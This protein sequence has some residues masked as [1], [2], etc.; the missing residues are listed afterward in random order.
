MNALN[1]LA[2]FL[3][4]ALILYLSILFH[5]LGHVVLG[6]VGGYEATSFGLGL[7][8]VIC[9]IPLGR[10]RLFFGLYRPLQGVTF[11][12]YP[13]F[14]PTRLQICLFSAGGIL[15]NGLLAL[16][17]LA[18]MRWLS[19]GKEAWGLLAS[20]NGLLALGS[21]VP[22][23]FQVGR[24]PLRSDGLLIL[25]TLLARTLSQPP[26]KTI[27]MAESL[28]GLFQATGDLTIHRVYLLSAAGARAE[29]A[30]VSRA[31]EL[32]QEADEVPEHSRAGTHALG[33]TIRATIELTA[34]QLDEAAAAMDV[35]AAV[36]LEEGNAKGLL[37][38][39]ALRACE[40]GLRGDRQAEANDLDALLE[41]PQAARHPELR[42][43]LLI[44]RLNSSLAMSDGDSVGTL[45]EQIHAPGLPKRSA[46]QTIQIYWPL[47]RFSKERSDV[48]G[49]AT[50]YREAS[51]G[52]RELVDAWSS[53]DEKVRFLENNAKFLTDVRESLQALGKDELA[54]EL[55]A[56]FETP[57]A[58]AP[59]S[60]AERARDTRFRRAGLWL[61][62]LNVTVSLS[63]LL[64]VVAMHVK[65]P[66]VP[67]FLF[68]TIFIIST[69]FQFVTVVSAF[70]IHALILRSW[71]PGI[72]IL[73]AGLI[74]WIITAFLLTIEWIDPTT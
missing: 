24:T 42:L 19:W 61:L 60:E 62:L 65:P 47:A 27:E 2:F 20:L 6:R 67:F 29:L 25:Q 18:L 39:A 45:L 31:K 9:V 28:R 4:G 8:R 26:P 3:T 5:E 37:L 57:G 54:D 48:E 34:G 33:E 68:T 58:M 64:V 30:D 16:L 72:A 74:P 71:R 23:H 44:S 43:L 1:L 51:S 13:R 17:G 35:A 55:L 36:C 69:V 40:K 41:D 73:A 46:L 53:P 52:M 11:A 38:I 32:C 12:F 14:Y 56:P 63:M 21:L 15:A 59:P 66:A 7:G 22:V 50:A 10:I 49:A 70:A